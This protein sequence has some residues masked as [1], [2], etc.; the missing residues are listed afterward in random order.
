MK[1]IF[2][3]TYLIIALLFSSC[4]SYRQQKDDY[5]IKI[6]S[7]IKNIN[8]RPFNGVILIAQNGRTKYSKAYGY[9]NFDKKTPLK[10]SDQFEIMS[11]SKQFTAVLLLREVEKGNID[12]HSSIK[13]YLPYLTQSWADT[14]TVHQLL[15]HTHGIIDTEKP[16]LFKAGTDFKYGNLSYSL[17]GKIIEYSSK[18]SY[19]ENATE[20]FKQLKMNSTF[21]YSK[22]KIQKLISGHFNTNNAFKVLDSTQININSI[23][24]DGIVS[25]V[26]DL[27]LWDDN[28]HKGKILNPETYKLMATYTTL[29]QHN[30]FGKDKIG[31]GYG[32]RISDKEKPKYL[33]HTGLGDG[34]ASVNLYFPESDVCLIVLENQMNDNVDINYYFETEIRKILMKSNLTNKNGT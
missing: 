9:A 21:C 11:N 10:V 20:L 12:L 17:L 28:L 13:K 34:F 19:T 6:D 27:A 14:V 5:S 23:A 32:I 22:D 25:T 4:N 1:Q 2:R 18:K 15:N 3:L 16:L 24:A 8:V 29:A 33:G 26:K 7:L 30:V 31:Y